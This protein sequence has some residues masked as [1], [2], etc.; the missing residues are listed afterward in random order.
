MARNLIA[1]VAIAMLAVLSQ[2]T[3]VVS[4]PELAVM[5]R[6]GEIIRADFAPGLHFKIPIYNDVV[7]FEKR[8]LTINNPSENFLTNE[9]KN[10]IVDFFVK[11]RITDAA[12]YYR[13]TAGNEN[14]AEQRLIEIIK[15]GLRAEFAKR[16]IQ[17][18]VTAERSELIGG[19]LARA[20]PTARELGISIVDVRVKRLDLPDEVSDSVFN[21]MRQERGRVASQLRAEGAEASE[22]IRAEADRQ[23]TVI[24][25]EAYRDAERQRGLGDARAAEIYA[26]AYEHNPEFYAFYRSMRAYRESIGQDRDILV[27]APNSDF[28]K[29]LRSSASAPTPRP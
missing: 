26:Q 18:V 11:W 13:A 23:R 19:M 27:L 8:I 12:Q 7:K 28:F 3:F 10:L 5:F 1:I 9:K 20:G 24:L 6:F 16:T 25:A 2:A 21:R 29:Y 4:E 14:I 22:R 15:D 17:Q